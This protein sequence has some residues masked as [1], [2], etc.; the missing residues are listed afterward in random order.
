VDNERAFEGLGKPQVR[1]KITFTFAEAS[2]D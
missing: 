2:G 1:W